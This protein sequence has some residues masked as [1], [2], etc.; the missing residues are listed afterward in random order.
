MGSGKSSSGR[1]IAS[2]LHWNFADTDRLVEEKEGAPLTEIFSQKGEKYFRMAEGVAL[3]TVSQRSR[4]VVACGGGTPCS[5]ENLAVMKSTG[6]TVYL[7][8]TVEALA[9]RLSRSG[10]IRPLILGAAGAGLEERIRELL[11]NRSVWYEQ[12]DLIIEGV[13][14]TDEEMTALI[15]DLVRS[16]GAYL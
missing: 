14:N 3:R 4:T 8:L 5:A 15:A 10:T 7:K 11:D 9:T 16:R 2:S 13:D 6:V 1:K 12:A